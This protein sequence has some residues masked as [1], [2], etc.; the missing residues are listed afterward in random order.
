MQWFCNLGLLN[1]SV[2][3]TYEIVGFDLRISKLGPGLLLSSCSL[4]DGHWGQA[5]GKR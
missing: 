2:S 5:L 1:V 4:R 3:V